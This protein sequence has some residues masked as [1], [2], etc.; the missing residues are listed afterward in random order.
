LKEKDSYMKRLC[1]S[2]PFITTAATS[3]VLSFVLYLLSSRIA[4]LLLG[5][6]AY[7]PIIWMGCAILSIDSLVL[8]CLNVLR[9]D[10]RSAAYVL[11]QA[12]NMVLT[13]SLNLLFLVHLRLGV[14]GIFI[15]NLISSAVTFILVFPAASHLIVI[16]Y[17]WSLLRRMLRFGLPFVPYLIGLIF[18]NVID[19]YFISVYLGMEYL[20]IYGAGYK[21]GMIV[22]LFVTSFRF[23]WHPFFMSIREIRGAEEIFA[24]VLTY[25]TLISSFVFLFLALYID[26]IV[27]LTVFGITLFRREYW[28]STEIAVVVMVAYIFYGFFLNFAVGIYIK[29]KTNLLIL[30]TCSAAMLNI[31]GNI[32]LI[33]RFHLMGAAFSTLISYIFM[34]LYIYF[35]SKRYYP[36]KY[37]FGR[38]FKIFLSTLGF[39]LMVKFLPLSFN[40]AT[41]MVVILAHLTVLYITG[42]FHKKEISVV[43]DWLKGKRW[44]D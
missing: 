44:R 21:M 9:A 10:E 28:A 25:F 7:A 33:P 36:I 43:K 30:S 22:T 2:T 40:L 6:A 20:A 31:L 26:D 35:L 38:I 19:R 23:A 24:R 18:L 8:L 17:S 39:Y 14:S 15:A 29:E 27:K 41:K 13:L 4:D 16:K 37:E 12:I 42:F 34:A 3:L 1:F 11:I 32:V 5:S